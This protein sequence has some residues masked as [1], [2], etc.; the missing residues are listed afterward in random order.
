M[1]TQIKSFSSIINTMKT[2]VLFFGEIRGGDII[3][4]NIYNSIVKPNNADVFMHHYYY[5]NDL[6]ENLPTGLNESYKKYHKNK[7]VHLTPPNKL[8]EI[9]NP[10]QCMIE[11]N[12]TDYHKNSDFVEISKK[13]THDFFGEGNLKKE[14]IEMAYNTIR[15]QSYS[16]K[17]VIEMKMKFEEENGFKYDNVIITRLDINIFKPMTIVEKIPDIIIVKVMSFEAIYEQLILSSS[18]VMD[19]FS[20]FHNESVEL[21]KKHIKPNHPFMQN[22]YFMSLFTKKHDIKINHCDF[23]LDYSPSHNG[24]S[25]FDTDYVKNE[26]TSK[27]NQLY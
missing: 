19:I 6:L 10:L 9:F 27:V 3:W 4:Q 17:M 2:A 12:R 5:G 8:F 25:R 23:P 26:D 20:K 21:Y 14:H 11:K 22:E 24:L 15:S 7:A 13:T 18:N 16:R 1:K